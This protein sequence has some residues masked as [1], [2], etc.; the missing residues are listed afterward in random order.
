MVESL[1]YW[2]G[3]ER[4]YKEYQV[5]HEGLSIGLGTNRLVKDKQVNFFVGAPFSDLASAGKNVYVGSLPI[6]V[7][8]DSPQSAKNVMVVT[9]FP[10]FVRSAEMLSLMVRSTEGP[11]YKPDSIKTDSQVVGPFTAFTHSVAV[12][13]GKSNIAIHDPMYMEPT[14]V[15]GVVDTLPGGLSYF[16]TYALAGSVQLVADDHPICT[17]PLLL[18]ILDARS[19]AQTDR[20]AASVLRK[21]L[22]DQQRDLS[23]L[24][25]QFTGGTA[26]A[27]VVYTEVKKVAPV[28]DGALFEITPDVYSVS[29]VTVNIKPNIR[30]GWVIAVLGTLLVVVIAGWWWAKRKRVKEGGKHEH[31]RQLEIKSTPSPVS[32]PPAP[33]IA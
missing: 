8:N 3:I 26:S 18:N 1:D 31:T 25:R 16:V 19:K 10:S 22:N 15:K 30:V 14:E 23:W 5:K 20:Q 33:P 24:A 7:I 2:A 28:G 6:T 29:I 32:S 11:L 27:Y 13:H 21:E 17:Y 12:V 4:A 9:S